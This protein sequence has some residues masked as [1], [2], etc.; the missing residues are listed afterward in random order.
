MSWTAY[1]IL[2]RLESP[3]HCG[4]QKQG[5]LL[6]TRPYVPGRVFWGALVTK[7]TRRMG[8][9][10][11]SDSRT[12]L[13]LGEQVNECLAFTYFYPAIIEND[14]LT[15]YWPWIN[16]DF[17]RRKFLSSYASTALV[18][19]MQSAA[20]GSLHEIEFLTPHTLDEGQQVYLLGYVFEQEGCQFP[21]KEV[22]SRLQFGAERNYGWGRVSLETEPK[23]IEGND[24][25][26]DKVFFDKNNNEEQE[27][28]GF[29][30]KTDGARPVIKLNNA[31]C[32][33]AH[34]EAVE[35]VRLK[36]YP[37]PLVGREW[38]SNNRNN[39]FVGQHIAF[40]GVC[41]PPGSRVSTDI[42]F[43]IDNFGIWKSL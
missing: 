40:N 41:Y 16:E 33:I 29:E 2:F 32:V 20:E 11:L 8:K 26:F 36:G 39:K 6:S 30:I 18:Y 3:M 28:N 23:E 5:N 15:M 42:S 14:T 31:D 25:I 1:E 21:W 37:E 4:Q 35:N 27:K 24:R 17:F 38:R 13:S 22:L 19:P 10:N 34:V 43:Q 9:G 12:Y 7:L